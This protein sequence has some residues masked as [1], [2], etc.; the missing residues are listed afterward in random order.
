MDISSIV[1]NCGN[2]NLLSNVLMEPYQMKI[3]THFKRGAEDETKLARKIPIVEAVRQLFT[4]LKE[5]KGDQIHRNIDLFLL[6][7]IEEDEQRF[8][9]IKDRY[10]I[11]E[12]EE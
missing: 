1:N 2:V 5:K 4:N 3:I 9:E 11:E 7:L 8:K 12:G 10:R 6:R